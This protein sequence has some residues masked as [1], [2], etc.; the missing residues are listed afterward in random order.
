MLNYYTDQEMIN[1]SHQETIL[2]KQVLF[3]L[4]I[5][6]I[7]EIE[8]EVEKKGMLGNI[9]GEK[10]IK[11]EQILF[12]THKEEWPKYKLRG[13]PICLVYT[14]IPSYQGSRLNLWK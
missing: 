3:Y 1:Q 6:F 5:R 8:E 14:N 7:E 4:L 10:L 13:N 9:L 12:S 11:N 2:N